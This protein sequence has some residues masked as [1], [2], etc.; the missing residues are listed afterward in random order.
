MVDLILSVTGNSFKSSLSS[1]I[2]FTLCNL[3][4][5][6]CNKAMEESM[7]GSSLPCLPIRDQ[8]QF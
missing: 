4:N 6:S 5:L 1:L 2:S 8:Q 7:V 3:L